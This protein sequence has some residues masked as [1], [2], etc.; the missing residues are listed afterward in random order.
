[1]LFAPPSPN[2]ILVKI[3]LFGPKNWVHGNFESEDWD[4]AMREIASGEENW[5][6][7]AAAM[8]PG[9]DA[10]ATEHLIESLSQALIANP[11]GTLEVLNL[12]K[13]M[14]GACFISS[15]S[16]DPA[17]RARFVT[18][19]KAALSTV[20]QPGLEVVKADCLH[21]MSKERWTDP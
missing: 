15:D 2:S 19:A 4:V 3:A 5:L 17:V 13:G 11:Q 14:I 10:D 12:R 1:M 18:N 16:T 20:T 21:E 8:A 7:V 6:K 9:T